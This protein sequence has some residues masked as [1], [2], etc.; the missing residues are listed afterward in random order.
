[1]DERTPAEVTADLTA[2]VARKFR[3]SSGAMTI[4]RF[5][6]LTEVG[7]DSV[8][9][10]AEALGVTLDDDGND[11][12]NAEWLDAMDPEHRATA[13]DRHR[14]YLAGPAKRRRIDVLAVGQWGPVAGHLEGVEVKATRADL[15]SELRDPLKAEAGARYCHRWW[16][17]L[18]HLDVA[19]GLD[20]PARWGVLVPHG[21][22]LKVARPAELVEPLP[23]PGRLVATITA[24]A[25]CQAVPNYERGARVIAH[26]LLERYGAA[27]NNGGNP[28]HPELAAW[29]E[30]LD[31]QHRRR[32]A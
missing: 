14:R 31:E 17:A 8:E 18:P 28:A 15:L 4:P 7:V 26:D 24:A 1:M 29:V 27:V 22:G 3:R 13:A 25:V 16:L 30:R 12:R 19:A 9:T 6:V 10:R 23:A 5:V 2:R 20:L 11:P 32:F 21:R